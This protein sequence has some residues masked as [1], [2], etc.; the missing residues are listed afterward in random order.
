LTLLAAILL[1]ALITLT[2]GRLARGLA[3][4]PALR[5]ALF[6]ALRALLRWP[7]HVMPALGLAAR[8]GL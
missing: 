4:L 6:L 5:L 1:R 2:L 3:F 8:S 7:L